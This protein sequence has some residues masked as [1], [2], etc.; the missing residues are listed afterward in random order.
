[1]PV[2]QKSELDVTV[3]TEAN[4]NQVEN[5]R[6]EEIKYPTQEIQESGYL[7][8]LESTWKILSGAAD[9]PSWGGQ[10]VLM[11]PD[12][13]PKG[14]HEKVNG[15]PLNWIKPDS[16]LTELYPRPYN[17]TY[18]LIN[19]HRNWQRTHL[20]SALRHTLNLSVITGRKTASTSVASVAS[21]D[22]CSIAAGQY[23]LLVKV[24]KVK[25]NSLTMAL[26]VCSLGPRGY[27]KLI[28]DSKGPGEA[29]RQSGP[30]VLARQSK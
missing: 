11:T 18:L 6:R 15:W 12:Q 20:G 30:E 7:T 13:G 17:I 2:G 5:W 10:R 14:A 28:S 19:T 16:L 4:C 25:A 26:G 29:Q 21:V 9:P 8:K 24:D 27:W 22:I 23:P 1:M 3:T